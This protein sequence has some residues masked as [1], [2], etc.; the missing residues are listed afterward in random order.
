MVKH[1]QTIYWL[2][3]TNCL[4][5][6]DYFIELALKKVIIK[7]TRTI[8]SLFNVDME[9]ILDF[10]VKSSHHAFIIG[11]LQLYYDKTLIV[12]HLF[13]LHPFSTP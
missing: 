3:P 8:L 7:T 11:S 10:S 12:T 9:D 4:S 1:T 6:F 5:V 2:L 13:S